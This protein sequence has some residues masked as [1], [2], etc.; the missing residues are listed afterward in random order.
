[1]PDTDRSEELL[2]L[3][4]EHPDAARDL[5]IL[6]EFDIRRR[7]P[8]E[9][10]SIPCGLPLEVIA[11]D[12]SGG[13]FFLVGAPD[14]P[15]RPVLYADSEGGA[16]LVAED[17]AEALAVF[18]ALGW[19][20]DAGY[21]SDL[22]EIEAELRENEPEL[23]ETRA[24][25]TTLLGLPVLDRERARDLLLA[26]AARTAPDYVPLADFADAQPYQLLFTARSTES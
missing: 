10:L 23:D 14:T 26:A 21:G 9:N 25:L 12:G 1:M 19:W 11:G 17:L 20:Q 7:D 16:S 18:I 6:V 22:A 5:E 3:I 2:R 8:V 13:S 24:A 4:S 15:R